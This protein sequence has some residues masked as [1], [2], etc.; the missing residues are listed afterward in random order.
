[1]FRLT[2]KIGIVLSTAALVTSITAVQ[3]SAGTAAIYS[4]INVHSN[5]CLDGSI[6]QGVRLNTCNYDSTYQQWSFDAYDEGYQ[7]KNVHSNLC[8]DGSISQGVRLNTCNSGSPYQQWGE[9]E[10]GN[11]GRYTYTNAHSLRCLD[12]SISQGVRLNTCNYGTYQQWY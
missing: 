2:H 8:L 5:L 7:I 12:G 10:V 3:A 1:M 9:I 6:S 11:L 4:L